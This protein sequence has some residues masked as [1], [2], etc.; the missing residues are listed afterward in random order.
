[1]L[2]AA[3]AYDDCLTISLYITTYCCFL[4]VSIV[5][6]FTWTRSSSSE[7]VHRHWMKNNLRCVSLGLIDWLQLFMAFCLDYLFIQEKN[8]M[9]NKCHWV[10]CVYLL[11][12]TMKRIQGGV[13]GVETN[14]ASPVSN[15]MTLKHLIWENGWFRWMACVKGLFS[16]PLHPTRWPSAA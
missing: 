11:K 4:L 13:E 6:P 3:A 8:L 9:A 16:F 5:K 2:I 10:Y 12:I 14:Y 1:M 7:A 15:I